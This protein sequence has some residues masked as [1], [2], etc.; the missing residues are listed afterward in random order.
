MT[1]SDWWEVVESDLSPEEK[2][3]LLAENDIELREAREEF[4][5]FILERSNENY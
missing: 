2:E 4:F 1:E 3:L 5:N